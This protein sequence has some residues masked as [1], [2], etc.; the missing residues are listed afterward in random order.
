MKK[1]ASEFIG[2]YVLIF[3]GCGTAMLFG[4]YPA[5]GLGYI[6]TALAFGLAF[7][8]MAFCIGKVSGCHLNPAVSLAALIN[9]RIGKKE[10]FSYLIAQCLASVAA[11]AALIAVFALTRTP[12]L[13][14]GYF[15]ND[16]AGVNGSVLNGLLIEFVLTAV[17]VFVFLYLTDKK[18]VNSA[19]CL[20]IG[21]V[22]TVMNLIGIRYT[23]ASL[24]PAR[25]FGP[26]VFAGSYAM[27]SLWIFVLAPFAG[28]AVAAQAYRLF[29]RRKNKDAD[30]EDSR[31]LKK[32]KF[33]K[34]TIGFALL[35]LVFAATT[36]FGIYVHSVVK[37]VSTGKAGYKYSEEMVDKFFPAD[38]EQAAAIDDSKPLKEEETWAVYMYLCASNLE[39]NGHSQ[40]SDFVEFEVNELT[41]ERQAEQKEHSRELLRDFINTE[42]SNDIP[43]PVSFYDADYEQG[44][45]EAIPEEKHDVNNYTWGT[46]ILDQFRQAELPDNVT[47]VVQP[48][49]A[50]AWKDVQVN[51]NRTRRF[52]KEGSSLV[53]VYDAPVA[54]M[55]ESE[56]LTDFLKFCRENYP[57]DHTMVILTDHGGATSGFGWDYIY[58]EDHL[59]L[60][61]LTKA[62]DD[63]YGNNEKNPPIDLLYFNAC[64]MSNTDVINAMRGVCEYMIA[65]EEVGLSVYEY[66]GAFCDK[67]NENPHM[68]A[69]QLGKALID[70]YVTDLTKSGSTLGEP[71]TTGL[72]LLDMKKAP[73]VFDAYADFAS[74]ALKDISDKPQILVKLSRAVA[75]SISFAS[76]S[77]KQFNLTDLGLWIKAVEDIYPEESARIIRLID[78]SILYKRVDGYLGDAHGISV[79][80]PNYIEDYRILGVTLNYLEDISY[81]EDISA[82]YYL[83]LAGCLNDK[84]KDYCTENGIELPAKIDY[85]AM[86]LLRNSELTPVD[87]NGNVC[88]TLDPATFPI[89]TDARYELCKVDDDTLTYYGEDRFVGSDGASGIKTDFKGKWVTFGGQPLYVKVINVINDYIIY[90]SPVQYKDKEYK[91]ILQCLVKDNGED[92]FTVLGL[93]QPQDDA[94]T[95]DRDVDAITPGSYITPIYYTAAADGGEMTQ[96]FGPDIIC[97]SNTKIEDGVLEKGSYRVRIV[98]EDM[99]GDDVFSAPVYFEVK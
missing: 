46:D 75:D 31:I 34:S 17:Y 13:Y 90:E 27:K 8:A 68:N 99:R 29:L 18:S 28:A 50:T 41:A 65:G 32:G 87:E 44:K 97:S 14:G 80:F 35:A 10:F 6:L 55:G 54:N 45:L 20:V 21:L 93:R 9:G 25:A 69:K 91:L 67:I 89:I 12:D 3:A 36:G 78:D 19:I 60:K 24:N 98:Y 84:Y 38:E 62:F 82:L 64:L 30:G 56:T 63:A 72:N 57:A 4:C 66:Y 37:E 2:T 40:L 5:F 94:A 81:S 51:P 11:V 26:A 23:G 33:K 43:M 61:E 70:C 47:F 71:Q 79:F 39:L 95:I 22:L 7:I 83:K 73:L 86:N 74:K 85:S 42:S 49:G 77:Y 48:G 52:V 92:E 59:T 76:N 1:F 96:T 53:E 15:C 88:A 16:L 58:G